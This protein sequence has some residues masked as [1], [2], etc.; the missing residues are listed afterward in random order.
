MSKQIHG[1]FLMSLLFLSSCMEQDLTTLS[2]NIELE[3]GVAIPLIHSTT[4]L[5]DLLP[6]NENMLTDDD[7][8]IRIAFRQDSIAQIESDSLLV[9]ENQEPTEEQFIVGEIALPGFDTLMVVDMTDLIGNLDPTLSSQITSAIDYSQTFG[10]AYFPPIEQQSGGIYN[11]QVSDQFHSVFIS[12]GQLSIT[13]TNNLAIDLSVLNLRLSNE[14]DNSVVGLFEFSNL[15][16]GS[17]ASSSISIDGV[18]LY[19]NLNMEILD[20][21]SIG[22]GSNESQWVPISSNDE[23]AIVIEGN[24]L[25]ITEGMVKLPYQTGP[26]DT[27]VVDMDFED[28]AEIDFI[29]LSAGQFVYSFNSD[30][31]TTLELTLEIPQLVDEN[32]NSFSEVI[33]IVNS[34]LE[35]NS[36]SLENYQFDFSTSVNQ[37]QINYSS[38]ILA[39][40]DYVS[41]DETNEISFSIGMENLEFDLIQGYFGQIEEVL[42]EDVLDLDLSALSEIASG[43]ILESPS[44]T[45]TADNSIGIPFKIDLELIGDNGIEQVSLEGPL[46]EILSEEINTTTFDNTNSQLPELITLNPTTVTYSGSVVSNPLGN[47]GTPNTLRPNTNITLGF[48]MDLPLYLRI[49][50]AVTTDTLDLTFDFDNPIDMIESVKMKLRIQNEFPLDVDLT[51]F[52]QDSISGLVL[53]SLNIGLLQAAEVDETGKTKEPRIYNSNISINAS[54]FDA[55]LNSNKTI[56][57]IR[58]SSYDS[59]NTAIKL[60]TDYEFV[61]DAG[62]LID[63][64]IEE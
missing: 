60:Y 53:D 59:D 15:Q 7:G 14:I 32:N 13:I 58:M 43:I 2:S 1:L 49:Q 24:G 29:E 56:I 47:T 41:Y 9:I 22:T 6:D 11:A 20:L 16:A 35:I 26:D 28:G 8:L 31:N 37:L 42:A 12:E 23:L 50:D 48:E 63:L 27:F 36:V 39:S 33:Q 18:N 64:K 3:Y 61:I 54:Q 45:F 5:S 25:V 55:L 30:L 38:Q 19:S 44:L 17:V 51:M 52:F 62:V 57:D 10:T 40:Q 4:T 34:S 21:A 46:F